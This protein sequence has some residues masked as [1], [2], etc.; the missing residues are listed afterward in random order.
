[1]TM[2]TASPVA[3]SHDE[4]TDAAP[5]EATPR[6]QRGDL[7]DRLQLRRIVRNEVEEMIEAYLGDRT[8]QSELGMAACNLLDPDSQLASL[9]ATD[10][11]G[12]VHA[13]IAEALNDLV[14][15]V[16]LRTKGA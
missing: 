4:E 12:E 10:R 2:D 16:Q 5:A 6:R 3:S 11:E 7:A 15:T 9:I 8:T 13:E 14:I 1:M